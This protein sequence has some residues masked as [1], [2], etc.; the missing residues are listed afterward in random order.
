VPAK[1]L[2]TF[3]L[4]P[5]VGA[6]CQEK[7]VAPLPLVRAAGLA[8]DALQ[9]NEVT[10]PLAAF[11]ALLATAAEA[12]GDD[13]L[14]LTL[15]ERVPDGT[16]SL[17]EFGARSAQTLRDAFI[18]LERFG[19]LVNAVTRF[20]F[21]ED[22]RGGRFGHHT[23]APG[24]TQGRELHEFTL[25]RV[26]GIARAQVGEDFKPLE[27]WFSHPKPKSTARLTRVFGDRLRF[28]AR[29]DGFR[30]E[31][32]LLDLKLRGADPALKGWLDAQAQEALDRLP[33]ANDLPGRVR[34]ALSEGLAK[35]AGDVRQV[36]A[37]LKL[38]ERTLQRKL[39]AE[40]VTFAAALEQVRRALAERYLADPRL[41]ISEV[42]YLL[43]YSELRAF[44]RAFVRW[45]R[46]T[47]SA[48]RSGSK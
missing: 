44:D 15:A 5:L 17:V 33:G 1:P 45:Y 8:A 37:A 36:A 13:A 20:S 38:S 35:G 23:L 12:T 16:Y 26:L 27:V 6:I 40:G 11:R 28:S 39:A 48:W 41:S 22:A 47:P 4:V 2:F 3:R 24:A 34:A 19:A 7:G 25:A 43:G 14:G 21:Q 18:S 9:R 29:G 32:R 42:A 31:T 46:Q 30:V 10:A